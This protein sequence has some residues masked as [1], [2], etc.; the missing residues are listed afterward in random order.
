M[1]RNSESNYF[2]RL[3]HEKISHAKKAMVYVYCQK[4]HVYDLKVSMW[5]LLFVKMLKVMGFT[6]VCVGCIW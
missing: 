1:I 5:K 2:V 6:V 3:L 4:I